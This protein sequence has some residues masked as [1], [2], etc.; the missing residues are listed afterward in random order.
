MNQIVEKENNRE[1]DK[2]YL[3]PL[4]YQ[5]LF[6]PSLFVQWSVWRVQTEP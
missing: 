5:T 6:V 3:A 4:I 1:N 2:E